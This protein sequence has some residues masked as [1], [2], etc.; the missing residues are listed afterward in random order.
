[1]RRLEAGDSLKELLQLLVQ[2]TLV[3][4]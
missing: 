1:M 4:G 3:E 2:E